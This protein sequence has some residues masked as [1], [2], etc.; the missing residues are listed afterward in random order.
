MPRSFEEDG[1]WDR[2]KSVEKYRLAAKGLQL[3]I[4][5]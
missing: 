3:A 1:A 5:P 2:Q 4:T